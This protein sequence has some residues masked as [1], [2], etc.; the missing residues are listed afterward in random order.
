MAARFMDRL[1]LMNY[2]GIV[3]TGKPTEVINRANLENVYRVSPL[4]QPASHETLTSPWQKM[5]RNN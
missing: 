3:S 5:D 4:N 2:G 1:I